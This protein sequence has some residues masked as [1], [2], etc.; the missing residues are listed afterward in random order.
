MSP[1]SVCR[2]RQQRAGVSGGHTA[3]RRRRQ[4]GQILLDCFVR[5]RRLGRRTACR[6][7]RATARAPETPAAR[8]TAPSGFHPLRRARRVCLR[9]QAAAQARRTPSAAGG[10][11]AG[12]RPEEAGGRTSDEQP[13]FPSLARPP[14]PPPNKSTGG[15]LPD[16]AVVICHMWCTCGARMASGSAK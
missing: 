9:Q 15:L 7:P 4:Q 13:L 14:A 2:R 8:A 10:E 5:T 12:C 6:Q 1:H 16:T 3:R 11:D